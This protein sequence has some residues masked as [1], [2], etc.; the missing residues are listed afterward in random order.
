MSKLS[1]YLNNVSN[2]ISLN[3]MKRLTKK[4]KKETPKI[5]KELKSLEKERE[6]IDDIIKKYSK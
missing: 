2:G 4:Y 5:L 1:E 6:E 3:T